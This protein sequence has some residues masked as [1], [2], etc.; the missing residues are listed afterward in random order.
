MTLI[1]QLAKV[2]IQTVIIETDSPYLRKGWPLLR[3][4]PAPVV[5]R[6][7]LGPR[8]EPQADHRGSCARSSSPSPGSSGERVDDAPRR[9]PSYNAGATVYATVRAARA[10]WSPVWVVVDGSDDGTAE[11]LREPRG[12]DPGLRVEVLP[13]NAGKG[14]AV[15]HGSSRRAPPASRMP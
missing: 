13:R 15:L 11:G 12:D 7:R 3:P 4:P 9:H 2:P 10:A 6:V 8:F 5:V 1:A 14:A